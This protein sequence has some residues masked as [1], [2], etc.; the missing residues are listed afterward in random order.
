V[1]HPARLLGV[2]LP[3]RPARRV[4]RAADAADAVTADAQ[5]LARAAVAARARRRVDARGAAVLVLGRGQADPAGRVRVG[6]AVAGDTELA[7]APGAARASSEWRDANPARCTLGAN[8]SPN[9]IR[10]GTAG[11]VVP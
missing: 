3:A 2:L 4:R 7:H 11:A 1:A 10:A 9:F 5:R 6:R 8:G